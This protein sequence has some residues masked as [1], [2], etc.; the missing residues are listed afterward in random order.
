MVASWRRNAL[1]L[2]SAPTPFA[3]NMTITAMTTCNRFMKYPFA[4][5]FYD[6]SAYYALPLPM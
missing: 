3:T 1:T 4:D 2:L 5:Y 6:L